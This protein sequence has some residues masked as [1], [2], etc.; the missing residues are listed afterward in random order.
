MT[1]A[2]MALSIII[3]LV[4]TPMMIRLLGQSEYGLYNTVSSTV[5]MLAVLN[6]GFSSGYI[7]Y[8]ARYKKEKNEQAIAKLNGLFL[9]IFLVIGAVALVCGLYLSFNLE[10]VFDRGLTEA[11]YATAKILFVLLTI[12]LALS[13]P[14][15]VFSGIISAHERFVFLKTMNIFKTVVSPLVTLPILLMGY[16]SVAMVAITIVITLFVDVVNIG[17]AVKVLKARFVFR[18]LDKDLF[19]NLFSYTLFIAINMVIDQ[20]NTNVDKLLLGRYAGTTAVAV[21]SVGFA[22]YHYYM[23]FSTAVSSVFT[24]RIHKLVNETK[25]DRVLQREMLTDLFVKV[26]RIQYLILALIATGV[27]F[28][29]RTFITDI[30]ATIDYADA[31]YVALMLILPSTIPLIQNIGIE[32]QRAQNLHQF[33]SICYFIMA[34]MNLGLSIVLCQ[35]YGVIG[36]VVGTAIAYLLANGLIMNIFYHQK[37]NLDIFA[38]WKSILGMSKGLIIPIIVGILVNYY[39]NIDTVPMFLLMVL[40]YSMFYGASMWLWGMNAYEKRMVL[41]PLKKVVKKVHGNNC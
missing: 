37:C 24:P 20:I 16:R 30:W 36:V 21:Y 9:S 1:Y 13:F 12:N 3:G 4:Y 23:M 38:F 25:D 32:I 39:V 15:S 29:G 19:R 26:G 17:Y 33:R 40:L 28:F 7:R 27:V 14:M 41:T 10:L 8:F 34:L 2:Q 35:A 11:E 22:L 18:S 5:A 6:L 31:Y